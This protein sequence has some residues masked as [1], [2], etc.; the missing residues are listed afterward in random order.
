VDA[1]E[2]RYAKSGDVNVAQGV[3]GDGPFDIVFVSGWVLSNLEVAGEGSAADFYRE[4]SS[5]CR[6]ILFDKRGTGLSDRVHGVPD[7]ETRMDDVRAVMDAAGSRRAAL[8]GFSEGGPMSI[9]FAATYP[10]RTAALFLYGIG[11]TFFAIDPDSA[12]AQSR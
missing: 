3:I 9:L 7:L 5:F 4:M 2:V 12:T 10:E 8:M 6:L 1:P 11:A